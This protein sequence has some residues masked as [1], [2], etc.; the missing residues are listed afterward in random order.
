MVK[1]YYLEKALIIGALLISIAFD[2]VGDGDYCPS[3][4][5]VCIVQL[6]NIIV[7]G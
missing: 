5:T 7:Y 1:N 3:Y 6:Y 4:C 2:L